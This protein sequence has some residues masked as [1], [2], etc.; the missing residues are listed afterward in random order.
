MP[1]VTHH[2]LISRLMAGGRSRHGEVTELA[3][4]VG[5]SANFNHSLYQ[6]DIEY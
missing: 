5:V 2:L 6:Q 3:K 1:S 4:Y